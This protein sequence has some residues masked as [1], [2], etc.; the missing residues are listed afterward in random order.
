MAL[1][2]LT[3]RARR[4]E[5]TRGA[6][7]PD[8]SDP[9]VRSRV[10]VERVMVR[11]RRS[12]ARRSR[13]S[14]RPCARAPP[15]LDGALK[16]IRARR[17]GAARDAA[18]G[19]AVRGTGGVRALEGGS[20]ARTAR[21]RDPH[22]HA[23]ARA[24]R[25]AGAAEQHERADGLVRRGGRVVLPQR[26]QLIPQRDAHEGRRARRVVPEHA[27]AGACFFGD[28][29][30]TAADR[31][32]P[33]GDGRRARILGRA[34]PKKTSIDSFIWQSKSLLGRP[35]PRVGG[36]ARVGRTLVPLLCRV[37]SCGTHTKKGKMDKPPT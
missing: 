7:D 15:L 2:A 14:D 19:P 33:H 35:I 1:R 28:P 36:F 29:M 9:L 4:D 31:A 20:A 27:R 22:A 17:R 30:R 6:D 12:P 26:A 37:S 10:L 11:F 21:E 23:A 3:G 24:D 13:R 32:A 5:R 16:G 25:G 18:P 8:G 34:S